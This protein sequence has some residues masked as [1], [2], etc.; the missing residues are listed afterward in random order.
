MLIVLLALAFAWLMIRHVYRDG[1]A[2]GLL[3]MGGVVFGV[4][5][6]VAILR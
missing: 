5:Y 4:Q 2:L 6:L 1:T 3:L